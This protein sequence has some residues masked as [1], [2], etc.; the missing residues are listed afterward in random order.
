MVSRSVVMLVSALM[1]ASFFL[2]WYS[3]EGAGPV[4]PMATLVPLLE[5]QARNVPMHLV[6][7]YGSFALAAL[8]T[9]MCLIGYCSRYVTLATGLLPIGL[10]IFASPFM[11]DFGVPFGPVSVELSIPGIVEFARAAVASLELGGWM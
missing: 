7:F 9:M 2:N 4:T 11:A 3:L 10:Y 6:L 5:E 1:A 8:G